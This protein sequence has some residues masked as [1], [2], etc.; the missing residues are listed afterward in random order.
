MAILKKVIFGT[1]TAAALCTLVISRM[2]GSPQAANVAA[3]P[4]SIIEGRLEILTVQAAHTNGHLVDLGRKIS[5]IHQRL[6]TINRRFEAY[7]DVGILPD[8]DRRHRINQSQG[9][10]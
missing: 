4:M 8:T 3:P 10:E 2:P 6:D 9:A 5:V 1:L 7:M